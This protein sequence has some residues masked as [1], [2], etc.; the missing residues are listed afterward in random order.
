MTL[1]VEPVA[2]DSV[3]AAVIPAAR[4]AGP[5]ATFA[6]PEHALDRSLAS[7]IAWMGA[8]RIAA[9]VFSWIVTILVVRR[10]APSDYG[11]LGMGSLYLGFLMIAAEFGLGTA[12]VAHRHLSEAD[13]AGLNTIACGLGMAGFLLSA[14]S[15]YPLRVFFHSPE[16]LSVV[17]VLSLT[18]VLS[19][20]RCVPQALLQRDLR[21]REV[22]LI[23]LAQSIVMA[24]STLALALLGFHYWALVLGALLGNLVSAALSILR[25]P[26][27]FARPNFRAMAS[28]LRLGRD[29]LGTR[30]AWY[31]SESVDL[32]VVGRM[33]GETAL[34]AYTIGRTIALLPLDKAN[35]ITVG[36]TPSI[37]S[38]S[39]HDPAL[40]RR[41][42]LLITTAILLVTLPATIGIGIVAPDLVG[43]IIGP[44]W[45][46]SVAP[47]RVLAAYAAVR[48]LDPL[49]TQFLLVTGDA[50]FAFRRNLTAVVVLTVAFIAGSRF[51]LVGVAAAWLVIHPLVIVV[52]L[53]SRVTRRFEVSMRAH[54]R[55]VVPSVV[56]CAV[57]AV[58]M[59]VVRTFASGLPS[60]ERLA[61]ALLTGALAYFGMLALFFPK[62][63]AGTFTA[64]RLLRQSL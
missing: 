27:R 17:P 60:S 47:L 32:A 45:Q 39:Q 46:E 21:F 11:I 15:A 18:F 1:P 40:L 10:L 42:V 14:L 57:M 48:S 31:T 52:P 30:L 38:A 62:Q 55:S 19:A 2:D 37:L 54:L 41:Y 50:A 13:Q 5:W 3:G 53:F 26:I 24:G 43:V 4:E 8:V 9:Q 22:A 44:H 64:M 20:V 56:S 59:Q 16:L 61:A 23:E 49:W 35:N 7:G 63:V 58:S 34:G 33:F 51:G 29:V 25:R 6:A 28:T 36:V 12:V